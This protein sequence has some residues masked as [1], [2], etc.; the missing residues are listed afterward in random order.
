MR[1]L[2]LVALV[3]LAGCAFP[4]AMTVNNACSG[5]VVGTTTKAEVLN[6]CGQP[7]SHGESAEGSSLLYENTGHVQ[8]FGFDAK[9]V[10]V[11]TG[12]T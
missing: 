6:K 8:V 3:S 12:G 7:R 5:F 9:G 10:L 1:L 2:F 4:E 11:N